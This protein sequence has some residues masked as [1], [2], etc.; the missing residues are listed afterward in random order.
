MKET[1]TK[2]QINKREDAPPFTVPKD[3]ILG[4]A[5]SSHPI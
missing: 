3:D 4:D 1:S 2:A 5:D